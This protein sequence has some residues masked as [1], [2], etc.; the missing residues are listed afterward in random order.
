MW[1]IQHFN[2]KNPRENENDQEI[3]LNQITKANTRLIHDSLLFCGTMMMMMLK[4]CKEAEM[5]ISLYCFCL[6]CPLINILYSTICSSWGRRA[7]NYFTTNSLTCFISLSSK[8]S[9]SKWSQWKHHLHVIK[10]G[11]EK[12]NT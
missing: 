9:P 5:E 1:N 2:P 4:G 7:W 12:R 6:F 11:D 8:L 3:L 10:G